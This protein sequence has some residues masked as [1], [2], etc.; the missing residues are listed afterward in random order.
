[1]S[2]AVES[3]SGPRSGDGPKNLKI[4]RF[5]FLAIDRQFSVACQHGARDERQTLAIA[6]LGSLHG[7][8]QNSSRVGD[9]K[10]QPAH[11]RCRTRGELNSERSQNRRRAVAQFDP[12][13]LPRNRAGKPPRRSTCQFKPRLQ[14]L[15]PR[16][17]FGLP[18]RLVYSAA[19]QLKRPTS[20]A[21]RWEKSK[22]YLMDRPCRQLCRRRL[23]KRKSRTGPCAAAKCAI[24]TTWAIDCC[25]SAPTASAPSTGFCPPAFP[26]KGAC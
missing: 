6:N 15:Q 8:R 7:L 19:H 10:T 12:L 20:R 3:N 5:A 16:S 13:G 4:P 18:T 14:R 2:V 24:S 23:L 9:N 17:P 21:A 1:M 25:W 22:F 11:G 26:T